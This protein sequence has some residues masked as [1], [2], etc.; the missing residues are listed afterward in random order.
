M[1]TNNINITREEG[2]VLGG[3]GHQGKY[4]RDYWL[5][6]GIEYW[7]FAQGYHL[8]SKNNKEILKGK[9]L[10]T[11]PWLLGARMVTGNV[12]PNVLGTTWLLP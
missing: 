2:L 5:S 9:K 8:S 7:M 3:V 10:K 6:G 4:K 12:A 1:T 11:T